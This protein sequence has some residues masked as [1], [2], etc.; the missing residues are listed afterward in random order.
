[1]FPL[2]P[3]P[4]KREPTA[5]APRGDTLGTRIDK[6]RSLIMPLRFVRQA[7]PTT[8]R[9]RL[10]FP[11]SSALHGSP[12]LRLEICLRTILR[13]PL[14]KYKQRLDTA[15]CSFVHFFQVPD[16]SGI[17]LHRPIRCEESRFGNV[18][19]GH[20]IPRFLVEIGIVHATLC[21]GIAVEVGKNHIAVGLPSAPCGK[22]IGNFS[23]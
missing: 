21:G 14:H 15:I 12:P 20:T 22:R 8:R 4:L 9:S 16:A 13:K 23:E 17:L 1:M 6:Y 18:D 19:K 11:S 5:S 3:F 7:W 10:Y 2:P